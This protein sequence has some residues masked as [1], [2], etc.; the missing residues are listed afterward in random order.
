MRKFTLEQYEQMAER[1][2]KKSFSDKIKTIAENKDILQLGADRNW[3]AV[4][5]KD[6][7][8][9]ESLY[10]NDTEFR[11]KNEWGSDEIDDLV[12]LLTIDITD[13]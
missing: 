7:E 9:Q 4:K 3:W 11:I 8:I 5:V 6:K 12:S 10:E 2:N 13:I 1:F